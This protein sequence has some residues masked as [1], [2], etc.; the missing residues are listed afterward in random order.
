MTFIY[1]ISYALTSF[2]VPPKVAEEV[3]KGAGFIQTATA[4]GSKGYD[5]EFKSAGAGALHMQMGYGIDM[6]RN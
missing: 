3:A 5:C 6:N 1:H 4:G 2:P